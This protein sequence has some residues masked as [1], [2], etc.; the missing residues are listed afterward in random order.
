MYSPTDSTATGR[1]TPRPRAF[2]SAAPPHIDLGLTN[3]VVQS[4][5]GLSVSLCPL[6]WSSNHD[7]E[8]IRLFKVYDWDTWERAHHE[9]Y[10][11]W[12]QWD[13][14][15][16]CPAEPPATVSTVSACANS[17][18]PPAAF[19]ATGPAPSRVVFSEGLKYDADTR[20][21]LAVA[22]A[23]YSFM[24]SGA[25]YHTTKDLGR[26]SFVKRCRVWCGGI[27]TGVLFTH[28]GLDM[29]FPPGMRKTYYA[30]Q[31]ANLTSVGYMHSTGRVASLQDTESIEFMQHTATTTFEDNMSA[32]NLSKAPAVT[33]RSRHIAIRHHFIRDCVQQ[34]FI[35]V[36]HLPTADMLADFL[37]KPFGPKRFIEFRN[38][39]FNSRWRV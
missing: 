28:V 39:I 23:G 14:Y 4:A 15:R 3:A 8:S 31:I 11:G 20:V 24:D 17:A 22:P 38:Q 6:N 35:D 1:L 34:G 7:E 36:Q 5:S 29:S 32:I 26:L 27:G 33:R 18:A 16:M 25:T 19:V 2:S 12:R 37:T 10:Q 13:R 9:R 30:E 21:L